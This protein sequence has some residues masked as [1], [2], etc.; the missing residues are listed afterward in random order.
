MTT[1]HCL[2]HSAVSWESSGL[3]SHS[4]MGGLSTERTQHSRV[5]Y[6]DGNNE[7]TGG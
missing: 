2:S 4:R 7:M 1:L 3:G 6:C 5:F